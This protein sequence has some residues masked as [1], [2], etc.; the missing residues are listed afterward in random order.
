MRNHVIPPEWVGASPF[1]FLQNQD[2]LIQEFECAI[3]NSAGSKIAVRTLK[4]AT[5]G[6]NE[7]M[8]LL[9]RRTSALA[10]FLMSVT[11]S[12]ATSA[13]PITVNSLLDDVFVNASGQ[14]FSDAAYTSPVVL[15]SANAPC[16]G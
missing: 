1:F 14:F 13:A 10:A 6:G 5:F 15:A 2:T 12:A 7:I 3:D 16:A 8:K 11:L 9:A 4:P